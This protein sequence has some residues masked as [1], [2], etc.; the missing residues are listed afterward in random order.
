[1]ENKTKTTL[2][3]LVTGQKFV[4][5]NDSDVEWLDRQSEPFTLIQRDMWD[6]HQYVVETRHGDEILL[7][8][9]DGHLEVR[10]V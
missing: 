6:W 8:E 3:D 1:M 7:M 4:F 9:S 2:A 5:V 10:I